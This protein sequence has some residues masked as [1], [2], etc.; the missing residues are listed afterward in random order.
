M[1]GTACIRCVYKY[2]LWDA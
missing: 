2:N 1:F